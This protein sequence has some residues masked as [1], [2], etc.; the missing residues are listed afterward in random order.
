MSRTNKRHC[1]LA[2]ELRANVVFVTVSK[3][4]M[5]ISAGVNVKNWLIKAVVMMDLFWI[6]V[7][8]MWM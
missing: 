7:L 4:G 1:V 2:W 5:K 3:V 8:W 6:L